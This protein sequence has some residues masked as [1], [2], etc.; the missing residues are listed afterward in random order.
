[1]KL[2]GSSPLFPLLPGQEWSWSSQEQLGNN[3][4]RPENAV[5]TQAWQLGQH[6]ST[7]YQDITNVYDVP[8]DQLATNMVLINHIWKHSCVCGRNVTQTRELW[9]LPNS[10]A[11]CRWIVSLGLLPVEFT[12]CNISA[13]YFLPRRHLLNLQQCNP[14]QI[15][16]VWSL[17]DG[18]NAL[19]CPC[20]LCG[21]PLCATDL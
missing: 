10:T 5:F 19:L 17:N 8:D 12:R 7:T 11:N 15:K 20:I 21:G 13:S 4:C 2:D 16:A 6:I 3:Q 14:A 9:R 18:C 1:M